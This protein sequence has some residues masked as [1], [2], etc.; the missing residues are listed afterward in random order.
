MPVF[1][2]S[3]SPTNTTAEDAIHSVNNVLNSLKD[4]IGIIDDTQKIFRKTRIPMFNNYTTFM[5]A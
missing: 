2:E 1:N 5:K 3:T 4:V